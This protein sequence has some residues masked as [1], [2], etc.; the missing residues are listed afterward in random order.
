MRMFKARI[1]G[2][3]LRIAFCG[4]ARHVGTSANLAA[5]AAGLSRYLQIPVFDGGFGE[6]A[7]RKEQAVWL[8]DCGSYGQARESAPSCDLLIVNMSIPYREL[9]NVYFRHSFARKNVIFLVGK[10]YPEHS[11]ELAQIAREYRISSSR[12][13]AIWHSPRF[14]KAYES[15]TVCEYLDSLQ[16]DRKSYEDFNFEKHLKRAV[17]AVITYGNRKGEQYYG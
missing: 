14:A 9:D 10:Y 7:G 13:C 6:G 12:I 1:G 15:N 8:A 2:A 11:G 5:V 16:K 4:I 3:L 17:D